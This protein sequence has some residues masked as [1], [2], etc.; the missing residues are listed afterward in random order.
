MWFDRFRRPGWQHRNPKVRQAAAASLAT[1]EPGEYATLA[2]LAVSDPAPAVRA[3][4][5]KRLIALETLCQCAQEDPDAA[6]R[7]AAQTRYGQ[8]L[9]E[10]C[11][12][13]DYPSREVALRA[14]QDAGVLAQVARFG[15]EPAIRVAALERLDDPLVLEEIING[16]AVAR[17]RR[18]AVERVRDETVLARVERE[19]RRTDRKVARL[20]RERLDELRRQRARLEAVQR[21]RVTVIAA[22]E[23]LA[24][25]PRSSAVDAERQRLLNRWEAH[26][27]GASLELQQRLAVVLDALDKA[28][29]AEA[30][31]EPPLRP[32]HAPEADTN[33]QQER[34]V[35]LDSVFEAIIASPEPTSEAV[36]QVQNLLVGTPD[37]SAVEPKGRVAQVRAWLNAA[38]RYLQERMALQAAL[39]GAT[40]Q[41]CADLQALEQRIAWPSDCPVPVLLQEG[42]RLIAACENKKQNRRRQQRKACI[43]ELQRQLDDL[44]AALSEGHLRP[45]RRLLQR[46]EQLAPEMEGSLPERLE[47]RLRHAT[48]QVAELRDWR[49]FA[50]LPKQEALC[51]AM[52]SLLED[53]DL[54]PPERA[55]RVRDLQSEWKA[56]GG[57]DSTRSQALWERFSGAADR[58]FE[59]CRAWFEAEAQRRKL[60]LIERERICGQLAEFVEQADWEAIAGNTL[61]QIR[62]TAR[63]EWRHFGPVERAQSGTLHE[64]FEAL[65]ASLTQH[66]EVKRAAYRACKAELVDKARALLDHD[67]LEAAAK[68]AK[69][70]QQEWN[71]L[72]PARSADRILWKAFRAACDELFAKRDAQRERR[73]SRRT[74]LLEEAALICAQLETLAGAGGSADRNALR[75]DAARLQSAFQALGLPQGKEGRALRE[76]FEA[77]DQALAER[78]QRLE[79]TTARRQFAEL[80][81]LAE[82]SRAWEAGTGEAVSSAGIMELPK[83]SLEPLQQRWA[84]VENGKPKTPDPEA[85]RRICIR[86]EI[87]AGIDSPSVDE[88]LRLE[89]QVERLSEGMGSG[90]EPLRCQEAQRLAAQWYGMPGGEAL[91]E[92]VDAALDR[93]CF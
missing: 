54:S 19:R 80:K 44:E 70:L 10:G 83:W 28:L 5:V 87:L 84:A 56:T 20:A 59:P 78:L 33:T 22:L 52:E 60:N 55:R 34:A 42:R 63:E 38:R 49:Q 18:R 45:A 51:R 90:K 32:E 12:T 2:S 4:A 93:L 57:S 3:T 27:E 89:L 61:E 15:R 82:L 48:I 11:E 16:D 39:A 31:G 68:Q 77:V 13:L 74:R 72:G 7:E 46:A 75:R 6:V 69:H 76:R 67:D 29:L 88:T 66:I 35:P 65:M 47:R 79:T 62:A 41:D 86:L 92:R 43:E 8:L 81:R 17:V 36:G 85:A 91:Q 71:A 73:R 26:D 23:A 64:R 40:E 30:N 37:E 21:E 9:A 24:E 1:A 53:P 50:V 14:C 58:A 25:H